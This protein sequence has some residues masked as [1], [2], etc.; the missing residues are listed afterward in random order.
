MHTGQCILIDVTHFG[1]PVCLRTST[2]DLLVAGSAFL[3]GT[4]PFSKG[5][6]VLL[7]AYN[8]TESNAENKRDVQST[9][10]IESLTLEKTSDVHPVQPSKHLSPLNHV[11][12]YI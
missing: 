2:I 11:P 9:Y 8:Y 5:C 7:S 3:V 10:I 6:H 4:V 12:Q 1:L